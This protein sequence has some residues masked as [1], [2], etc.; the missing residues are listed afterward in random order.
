MGERPACDCGHAFEPDPR[1]FHLEHCAYRRSYEP[2]DQP[3]EPYHGKKIAASP[4]SN[5][6]ARNVRRIRK[7]RG[8][9]I[10]DLSRRLHEVGQPIAEISLG[11]LEKLNRRID[12]DEWQALGQA[13]GVPPERLLAEPSAWNCDQ[14]KDCPPPGFACLS[15][16][17]RTQ[18]AP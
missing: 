7:E 10:G 15:C 4:L 17:L 11:R 5:N 18:E 2:P 14:C 6:V 3:S 12:V 1:A 16:G 9:T 13:L 8:L